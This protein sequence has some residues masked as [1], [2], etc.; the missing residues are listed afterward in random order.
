M[1]A[2][3]DRNAAHDR[4]LVCNCQRT[5]EIDGRK[6]AELLGRDAPLVVHTE[7]CRGQIAA[8]EQALATGG[9]VQIACTQ[10]EPLFRE[11]AAE[12][13]SG[14]SELA[15]TN[16]RE[17]AGW[18]DAK[19]ASLPKMTALLAAARQQPTPTGLLTLESKG[20]C[21]V[22]GSG[23]AALDVATDLAGRLSV[24]ALLIDAADTIPPA[25]A[26]FPISKGRI[27]AAKGHLGAFE[28]EVDGYAS[29]LPSSRRSLEF[30][31]ARDGARSTCDLIFDLSGGAPL[32]SDHRRDGY[33]RADPNSPSA[34]A[35]GM[36]EITNL[37]GEFEKPRYVAFD[38]GICAHARSQK[39]GCTNCLD[40]CPTGAITPAGDHVAIDPAV[41]GGC[42]NCSAVCPTGAVSY[43]YPRLEDLIGRANVLVGTY[44]RAGGKRPIVLLHDEKH[45][46]ALISALARFGRG[47]PANVLPLSL[48]SVMQ[49]GHDA[50]AA[51]LAMGAE[52]IAILAPPEHPEELSALE[53]QVALAAAFLAGLG[54][55]GPRIHVSSERDPEVVEDILYGLSELSALAP[56]EVALKGSKRDISRTVF[57]LLHDAAPSREDV[58]ALPKGAPYGRIKIDVSGCTLCLSCVGA[59]PANALS[60][61]PDRPEVAFTEA[62]CVQCGIC[63]ATCPEHVISLEPRY[64]FRSGA[65]GPVR[66]HGEEPFHCVACGKPF[67]TQSTITR[68]V[69]RLKGHSM[70]QNE[71]QLRL[72]Q[73]CDTCRVVA[74]AEEGNDPMRVGQR[75]RIVTTDD[76]LTPT[77]GAKKPGKPD[78]Y[79]D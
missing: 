64:D 17:A 59:C 20:Q 30:A 67:G 2:E 40:N 25:I 54:Y 58:I 55:S 21:L 35:R 27:R 11:V 52:Q 43:A 53:A 75:P 46:G 47:L 6:L 63:V 42:G 66:L 15:F 69:A 29:A 57:G 4:L 61:N 62:A 77:A 76:Y 41:C 39:V 7:L 13:G 8:F 51:I 18:S 16:I 78:D 36:L 79:L 73:M 49:V 22:Y 9:P 38:A 24:T 50:I 71:A 44:L 37:V 31:M 28:I 45:G 10:E 12:K 48:F 3:R 5:M 23:Q 1:K 26:A 32:F 72:I 14:E 65:L 19:A 33:L 34:V 68:V 70:F 60:D 74:V 56:R